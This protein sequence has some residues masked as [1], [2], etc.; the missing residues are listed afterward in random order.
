M[1]R[2]R[3]KGIR[4]QKKRRAKYKIKRIIPLCCDS[5]KRIIIVIVSVNQFYS[6]FFYLSIT[7][8]VV[9]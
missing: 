1:A 8:V 6:I 9:A 7:E 5:S 3:V 2:K 4:R